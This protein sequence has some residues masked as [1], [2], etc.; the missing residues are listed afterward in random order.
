MSGGELV[1]GRAVA[2]VSHELVDHAHGDA[3]ADINFAPGEGVDGEFQ[4]LG[5]GV[6]DQVSPGSRP[7]GLGN[8][9]FIVMH[10][11]H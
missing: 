8:V 2:I 3:A 1:Q 4:L 7:K 5:R 9:L 11:E 6:L 10:G